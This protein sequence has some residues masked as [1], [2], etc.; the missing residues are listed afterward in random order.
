LAIPA[1]QAAALLPS[2]ATT[3][4]AIATAT[5]MRGCWT[6]M[7]QFASPV[8][9]PF[10]AAFV[11]NNALSWIARDSNKPGR[12]G[13]ESWV[14]QASPEWSE[15]HLEDSAD[16][17]AAEL[18]NAF[19]ALGGSMPLAWTAHRWRYANA[20]PAQARGCVW[21]ATLG[22]GMCGDWLHGGKVEGAW[23]S[24]QALAQRLLDANL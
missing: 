24:G 14:L 6:L 12:A 21:D 1:P 10:D 3:L 15:A 23:L 18:I 22:I 7:L 2:T 16:S 13:L 11:H 8:S 20:E 4:A 5:S 19:I 9:L 17:V